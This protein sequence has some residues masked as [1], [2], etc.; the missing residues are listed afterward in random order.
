MANTTYL[1]LV[2][3]PLNMKRMTCKTKGCWIFFNIKKNKNDS[4]G[5]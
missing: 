2:K 3:K 1:N 5:I 4:V